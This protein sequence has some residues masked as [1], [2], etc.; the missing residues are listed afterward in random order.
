MLTRRSLVAGGLISFVAAPA[1]VRAGSLMPVKQ[2]VE[3][4]ALV[5]QPRPSPRILFVPSRAFKDGFVEPQNL[6]RPDFRVYFS[7]QAQAAAAS[8]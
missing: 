2:M 1:I 8:A 7:W 4:C 3:P 6:I 5:Y